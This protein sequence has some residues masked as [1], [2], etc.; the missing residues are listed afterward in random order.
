MWTEIAKMKSCMSGELKWIQEAIKKFVLLHRFHP[1]WFSRNFW[2]AQPC[3]DLNTFLTMTTWSSVFFILKRVNL[4]YQPAS[5][6]CMLNLTNPNQPNQDLL[7][8][9]VGQIE[10]DTCNSS[11][12]N[13]CFL[14]SLQTA[15]W[16]CVSQLQPLTFK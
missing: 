11:L 6:I 13:F 14:C 1:A 5:S 4:F 2:T 10:N 15:T 16:I 3:L 12:Y 9:E 8:H 7:L